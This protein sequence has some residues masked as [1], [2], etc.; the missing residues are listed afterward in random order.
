MVVGGIGAVVD[1]GTLNLLIGTSDIQPIFAQ[2]VSFSAA[3][4]SNFIWNRYWTYPDSRSKTV[5][6]Q[7]AQFAAVSLT[8]LGIRSLIFAVS[9][10][11]MSRVA[12]QLLDLVPI[13]IEELVLGTNLAVA[14]AVLVVLFWNFGV[15]RVWTY[16]D[17]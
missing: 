7:A 2:A 17:V 12:G 4:T 10:S 13:P 8:G 5:H 15:N 3:V 14:L 9:E 11:M 6:R 1:F 16:S